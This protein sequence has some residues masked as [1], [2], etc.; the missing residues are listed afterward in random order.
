ML[1]GESWHRPRRPCSGLTQVQKAA[2]HLA[3]AWVHAWAAGACQRAG[4][5]MLPGGQHACCLGRAGTVHHVPT[6]APPRCSWVADA[7]HHA[8]L[9]LR[10]AAQ[11]YP[12]CLLLPG[13]QLQLALP[14]QATADCKEDSTQAVFGGPAVHDRLAQASPCP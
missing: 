10:P 6:R 2:V 1:S 8:L 14:Q 7:C 11:G 5:G 13:D 3:V 12:P 4:Q 9:G